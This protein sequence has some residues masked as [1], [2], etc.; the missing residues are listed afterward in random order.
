MLSALVGRVWKIGRIGL[1]PPKPEA[2]RLGV[3]IVLIVRNEARH[4]REWAEFHALAGARAFFVYDDGCTDATLP[5]LRETVGDRLTVVPWRQRLSVPDTGWEIHNQ[6]LAYAHAAANFGGAFRWMTFIDADE[7]LVPKQT[8]SLENALAHLEGCGNISLPWH[9]FGHCGHRRPPDGGIVR[10]YL[11]RAADPMSD[12]RGVRAFKCVVDP[13][14]L[15]ALGVHA[16]QTDDRG[17]TC[18]DCGATARIKDRD[19][20][21]FYSADHLQLNHYYARS[22]AELEEKVGRGHFVSALTPRYEHKIRRTIA[23]IEKHTVEDRSALD[24]L[25]RMGVA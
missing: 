20:R 5:I 19:R 2:G 10:N 22:E 14:R 3:A 17:L 9:M 1:Q 11:R 23:N 6:V 8:A 13:C 21:T 7:F 4:I 18:N 12:A 25:N 24:Y 16:M 15:L